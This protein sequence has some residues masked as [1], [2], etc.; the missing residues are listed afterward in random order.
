MWSARH[1][2]P[3]GFDPFFAEIQAVYDEIGESYEGEWPPPPPELV[4]DEAA[5][6]EASGRFDVVAVRRYLWANEYDVDRYIGLLDTFSGH[7]AMDPDKRDYLYQEVRRRIAARP[8]KTV[9][10]HWAA[11][12]TIGQLSS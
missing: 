5:A 6:F 3:A 8:S 7:I 11:V 9:H 1:A 12:L 10:R 2:F 4:P